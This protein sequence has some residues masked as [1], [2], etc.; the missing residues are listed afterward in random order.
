MYLELKPNGTNIFQAILNSLVIFMG[1][2]QKPNV[3]YK[4]SNV[5]NYI[6]G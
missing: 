1:L 3:E 6:L 4:E 2:F 5:L